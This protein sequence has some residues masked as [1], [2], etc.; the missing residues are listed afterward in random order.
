[1][2]IGAKTERGCDDGIEDERIHGHG[3]IVRDKTRRTGAI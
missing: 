3:L 2:V 1:M